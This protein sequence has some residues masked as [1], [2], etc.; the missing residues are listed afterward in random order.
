M[1]KGFRVSV[2]VPAHNEEEAILDVVRSIP[3]YVDHMVVV[4]DASNDHTFEKVSKEKDPRLKIVRHEK[5]LGVGGAII[6]GHKAAMAFGSDVDVV[7]AGDGQMGPNYLPK[8]LDAV[9]E[10]YDYAKGNRFISKRHL[11][12][13]PAT[14]VIGNSVL[15]L[16]MKLASGY[17]NVSDSQNGYTAVRTDALKRFDLNRITKGYLFENDMLINLHIAGCSVKDV[18]IPARYP[19][20]HSQINVFQFLLSAIPFLVKG[21]FRRKLALASRIG[22]VKRS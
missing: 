15:S 12:G 9:A 3:D 17:W 4:D 21:F 14:R 7:M 18:P 20:R 8:L 16:M 10:G 19:P 2:V 6:T 5:N 22:Q 11:A 1:Y 13:M